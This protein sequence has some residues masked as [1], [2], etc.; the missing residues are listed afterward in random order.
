MTVNYHQLHDQRCSSLCIS[1]YQATIASFH[2]SPR[3]P[4]ST[5]HDQAWYPDSRAINH[6]TPDLANLSIVSPYTGTRQVSLGNGASVS[7]ANI[8]SSS[9]QAGSRL[10]CLQNV[11]HVPT[12]CKNLLSV[13][14]FSR[15]N[16]VYFEFHHLLC[17]VKDIPTKKTL[18]VG[19][20]HNGLYKFDTSSSVSSKHVACSQPHSAFLYTTQLVPSSTLWHRQLGHPCT[21]VLTDVL[22]SC[23]VLFRRS[24]LSPICS[25]CQ[26]SK[27]HK[28]PFSSSK[29]L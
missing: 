7:I 23:N 12:I 21:N 22:R 15:D 27:A 4:S 5:A 20:M 18:L 2:S 8:G 17:F 9:M 28:L 25:A 1:S 11:L 24:T 13:G 29:T 3:Q 26:L 6:I 10:F 19:H 16:A 14:Q